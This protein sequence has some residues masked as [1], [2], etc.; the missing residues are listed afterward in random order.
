MSDIEQCPR[1]RRGEKSFEL[2]RVNSSELMTLITTAVTG[3]GAE[4][5]SARF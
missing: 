5:I 3:H 4:I 2:A 1:G